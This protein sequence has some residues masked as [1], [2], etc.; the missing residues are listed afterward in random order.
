MLSSF[1]SFF[2]MTSLTHIPHLLNEY[3]SLAPIL[4][5]RWMDFLWSL[6][7]HHLNG[8]PYIYGQVYAGHNDVSCKG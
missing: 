6:S 7:I 1:T 4:L 3:P 8:N 2:I 5:Y